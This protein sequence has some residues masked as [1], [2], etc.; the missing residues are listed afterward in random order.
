MADSL[1]FKL[2]W[3]LDAPRKGRLREINQEARVSWPR[4]KQ[5]FKMLFLVASRKGGI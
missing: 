4:F 2:L 3:S 1:E 5:L